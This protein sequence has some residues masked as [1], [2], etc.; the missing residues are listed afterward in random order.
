MIFVFIA[1]YLFPIKKLENKENM[2]IYIGKNIYKMLILFFLYN[3]FF[4][5]VHNILIKLNIINVLVYT[6]AEIVKNSINGFAFVTAESMLGAFWFV[7]M[8][9]ISKILFTISIYQ[10]KQ[11]NNKSKYLYIL[12]PI[13][14]GIIGTILCRK[15]IRT[16]YCI[17]TSIL[18]VPFMYIGVLIKKYWDK[19][20]KYIFSFGWIISAIIFIAIIEMN[21][22]YIELSVNQIINPIAFYPVSIV[23]IYFCLSLAKMINKIQYIN[24]FMEYVGKNSFHIMALH[25]I[26][27]KIVDIVYSKIK[28]INDI[29]MISR[30]PNSY[31]NSLWIIYIIIGT[32]LPV[33]L[34][35]FIKR[36]IKCIKNKKK[37]KEDEKI[38]LTEEC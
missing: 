6:K 29:N 5:I 34:V 9:L 18:L 3:L 8:L 37:N 32:C 31:S 11:F 38:L 30:F 36:I 33:L 16:V 21:I 26:S 15:N 19:I 28:N 4:T 20:E 22:G 23:G 7:P 10:I 14:F 13:I 1:G 12:V 17:Q 24:T 35:F 27:I 25:F 2:Y